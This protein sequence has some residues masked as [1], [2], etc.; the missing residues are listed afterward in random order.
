MRILLEP[1]RNLTEFQHRVVIES[2]T[3]DLTL[4][5]VAELLRAA[6]IAYGFHPDN[7]D[8]LLGRELEYH[9]NTNLD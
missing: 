8:E 7:V 9:E 5:D 1:S 6:L 3:D 4:S 2:A